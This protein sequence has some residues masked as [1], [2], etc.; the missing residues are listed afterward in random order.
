VIAGRLEIEMAANIAR[1][2]QDMQQA[3]GVVTGAMAE[4]NRAV[5]IFKDTIAA[6]GV[7]LSIG[8]FVAWARHAIDTADEIGKLSQK[9]GIA[10]GELSKLRYAAEL[11]GVGTAE[12]AKAVK[13]LSGQMVEAGD[14]SSKASRVF[15]AMGIDTKGGP[16]VVLEKL[17]TV[18]QGLQDDEVKTTLA[19]Q[20]FGKAGMDLIPLLNQGKDGIQ[21]LKDEAQRL[22]IVLNEETSKSAEQFNDNLRAVK[23][24]S[25]GAA[26][27]LFNNLAPSLT[28]I[29]EAMKEAAQ[30]GGTLKAILVGFGGVLAETFGTSEATLR[31]QKMLAI[32]KELTIYETQLAEARILG[33]NEE[34]ALTAEAEKRLKVLREQLKVMQMQDFVTNDAPDN[35]DA[36]FGGTKPRGA[37]PN[38]AAIR[39]ALASTKDLTG[40]TK[41]L[42]DADAHVGAWLKQLWDLQLAYDKAIADGIETHR[43]AIEQIDK[44]TTQ[45]QFANDTRDMTKSQ[46][47]GLIIARLEEQQ[48]IL[49][50]SGAMEQDIQLLQDEINARKKLQGAFGTGEALEAQSKALR[51]QIDLWTQVGRGATDFFTDLFEHGSKA[52]G[53]LWTQIKHFF[54]QLA[55]Q[56]AT[57]FVLQIVAGTAGGAVGNAITGALGNTATSAA[58]S[59]FGSAVSGASI[60][61]TVVGTAADFAAGW[62][63]A[64]GG[65]ALGAVDGATWLTTAGYAAGSIP[66]VGWIIAAAAAVA[67]LY[68]KY[69]DRENWTAQLGFGANAN[70]YATQGVFGPE[71]FQHIAGRDEVNS[72]LQQMMASTGVMDQ[73]IAGAV[74]TATVQRITQHLGNDPYL[75]RADG[76]PAQFA[77][78]SRRQHRSRSSSRSSTCSTSTAPSSTDR[79]TRSPISSA[80]TPA[81]ARACWPRSATSWR[82][83]RALQ[84]SPVPGLDMESLRAMQ[85][86]GEKLTDTFNRI[87]PAWS[88]TSTSST[89]CRRAAARWACRCCSTSSTSS[90]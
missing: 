16:T 38:A 33:Q 21:K 61:G 31:Q 74:S 75:T 24:A 66:V 48:A 14:T 78:S 28:R 26:I 30:N 58:G 80:V 54:A 43:L 15:Q 4:M 57:R 20:L 88:P 8:G 35:W 56:F 45:E 77:F 37:A 34:G 2:Q 18:F 25:E 72:A 90:A 65:I 29:S 60:G 89:R 22:G 23:A 42:A 62:G 64:Q 71:G 47:Q 83:C 49:R 13:T 40:A 7:G 17:A 84:D 50:A 82:S 19:T 73:I 68:D 69:R 11:S 46:I 81:T 87:T 86:E 76:Q 52:F 6:L 67:A 63:A 27:N 44:Q 36:R 1:L 59:Y 79:R 70:A 3:K 5:G 39:A 32:V 9:T 55:A 41:D 85:R 10:V 12:L 51:E 53:N